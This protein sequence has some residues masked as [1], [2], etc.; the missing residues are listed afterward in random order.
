MQLQNIG[1]YKIHNT[2]SSHTHI[3]FVF[4][5]LKRNI[6]QINEIRKYDGLPPIK[7]FLLRH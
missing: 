6:G 3:F 5:F 4:F 2:I 7:R 1:E